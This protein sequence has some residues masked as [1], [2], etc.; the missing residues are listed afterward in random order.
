MVPCLCIIFATVYV[1][2]NA[3]SY[4]LDDESENGSADV[5]IDIAVVQW[6]VA[7]VCRVVQEAIESEST[8][9][10]ELSNQVCEMASELQQK[11][12]M[13]RRLTEELNTLKVMILPSILI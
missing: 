12:E 10:Q 2:E 9:V 6:V 13:L 8:H 3:V 11:D 1:L 5:C 4:R 7:N